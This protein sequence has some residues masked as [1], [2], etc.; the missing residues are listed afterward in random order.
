MSDFFKIEDNLYEN[1]I[2]NSE[3]L[4]KSTFNIDIN[5]VDDIIIEI[6]K[7]EKIRK[8]KR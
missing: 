6:K 8:K 3:Y 2:T 4:I 7:L 1:S 5:I